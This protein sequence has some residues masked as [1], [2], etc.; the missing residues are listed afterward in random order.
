MEAHRLAAW[1]DEFLEAG[2]AGL[3]GRK[4][5]S[6]EDRRLAEAERKI[7]ELTMDNEIL[8]RITENGGFRSRRRSVRA[9]LS[10]GVNPAEVA[11]RLGHSVD[12]LMKVYAG[13]FQDER[14]RANQ[15][16][17]ATFRSS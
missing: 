1:R 8:R 5:R 4:T 11:R 16:L 6:D 9:M 12:M 13:V 7:G 2:K 17:S 14:E 10:A 15:Q 3:K